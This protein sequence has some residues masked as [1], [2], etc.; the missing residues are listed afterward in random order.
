MIKLSYEQILEKIQTQTKKTNSEIENL[1]EKKLK[2]LS[3]LISKEG[4]AHIIANELKVK[5][6]DKI[7]GKQKIKD[8]VSGMNSVD[9]LAKIITNY[10]IREFQKENKQGRV[11][12]LLIGDDTGTCRMV[13]WDV[14][15]IK[16]IEENKIKE[17]K[18]VLLKNAYIKEN[19]GFKEV[20]LGNRSSI[21][22]PN[23]KINVI[24]YNLSQTLTTK[25]IK[26][27][28]PNDYVNIEGTVVQAFEPRFY[29]SC[30]ECRKKINEEG[31][32]ETHGIVEKKE[33]P[34]VNIY[35][36]DGTENIRVVL[37]SENANKLIKKEETLKNSDEFRDEVL[38]KQLKIQGRVIRNDMFD[39]NE[40]R[41]NNIEELKP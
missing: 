40:F 7:E 16:E 2:Q 28:I 15:H 18:V 9:V 14:N 12:S 20:H 35:I 33:V 30:P 3:D 17:E 6:L 26:D 21:E 27:L 31:K 10:G 41:A 37:F 1:V 25:K 22:Y 32:C 4:A 11:A 13:L 24:I 34:I 8:L 38:G 29:D 36:D 19:N 5:L 39:R 23:E